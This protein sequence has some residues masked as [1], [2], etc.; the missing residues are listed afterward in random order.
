MCF[1]WPTYKLLEKLRQSINKRMMGVWF[2]IGLLTLKTDP[3]TDVTVWVQYKCRLHPWFWAA[4]FT[5]VIK[6]FDLK[7]RKNVFLLLRHKSNC[8]GSGVVERPKA[9]QKQQENRFY[10]PVAR[11]II[12]IYIDFSPLIKYPTTLPSPIIPSL[13][14]F[15]PS[16]SS[17]R[18]LCP[19]YPS[20]EKGRPAEKHTLLCAAYCLLRH[21]RKHKLKTTT[22]CFLFSAPTS[23]SSEQNLKKYNLKKERK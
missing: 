7:E 9:E 17:L 1:I 6:E 18:L 4:K 3:S 10:L 23:D 12:Y 19:P 2:K 20:R 13:S 14:P 5:R 16:L 21:L 8:C 22:A 11:F 15:I